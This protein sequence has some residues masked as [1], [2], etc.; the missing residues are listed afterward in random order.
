M[1]WTDNP[2]VLVQPSKLTS[3]VPSNDLSL[4]ERLNAV[5]RL[6]IYVTV[7]LMVYKRASWPIVI[8]VVGLFVTAYI[9][10][11]KRK[12]TTEGFREMDSIENSLVHS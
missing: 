2:R 10:Q 7:A 1:F 9:Y 4:E 11:N 12:D 5:A 8:G 6:S 3:I